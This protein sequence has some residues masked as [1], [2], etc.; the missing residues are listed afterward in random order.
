MSDFI[1][2]SVF[3]SPRTITVFVR[4]SAVISLFGYSFFST[5]TVSSAVA[6]LRLKTF[7]PAVGRWPKPIGPPDIGPIPPGSTPP[8]GPP[9]RGPTPPGPGPGPGP[10]G[11]T[12]PGPTAPGPPPAP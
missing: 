11:P 4:G 2:S 8:I 5:T 3:S 6:Y 9:G 12:G 10:I 7:S 1:S